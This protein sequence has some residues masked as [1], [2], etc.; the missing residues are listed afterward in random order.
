MRDPFAN[1]R[2]L[3]WSYDADYCERSDAPILS[4]LIKKYGSMFDK[5]Y[6]YK[7]QGKAKQYIIRAPHYN[8]LRA[9]YRIPMEK[10]K[11]PMDPS[12]KRLKEF[13]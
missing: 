12:Q 10:Y 5:T 8:T 1:W 6:M 9:N 4:A 11:A 3:R 2:N 13:S 7:F